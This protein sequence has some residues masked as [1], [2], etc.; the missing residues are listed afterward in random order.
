M[1]APPA[2]IPAAVD[3][4]YS[5][6]LNQRISRPIIAQLHENGVP[7]TEGDIAGTQFT[8]TSMDVDVANG[9]GGAVDTWANTGGILC[10][11]ANNI[12]YPRRMD[13]RFCV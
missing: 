7:V 13:R 4:I 9:V 10:Q 8:V 12:P 2:V 11:W 1:E 6:P 5:V 3:R